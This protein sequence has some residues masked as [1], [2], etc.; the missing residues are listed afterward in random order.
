MPFIPKYFRYVLLYNQLCTIIKIRNVNLDTITIISKTIICRCIQV[1]PG[2]LTKV[3]ESTFS[4]FRIC[5][6]SCIQLSCLLTH[7]HSET[8]QLLSFV[9]PTFSRIK[10]SEIVDEM[11]VSS[12]PPIRRPWC[13]S[14][15]H[16]RLV[17]SYFSQWVIIFISSL[18]WCPNWPR[19]AYWEFRLAPE[20]FWHEPTIVKTLLPSGHIKM[21]QAPLV[22]SLPQSAISP[23]HCFS[24]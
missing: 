7:R 24:F 10:A 13:M 21:L 16:Y 19:L 22:L 2:V 15:Y 11:F 12:R 5:L 3:L 14:P 17:D 23:K 9:I 6:G 8:V 1:L 18:F 20:F 4:W